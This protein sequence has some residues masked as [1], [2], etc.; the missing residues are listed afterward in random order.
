[1]SQT[2]SAA[3]DYVETVQRWRE[4]QE[5]ELRAPGGW[6]S[7]IGLFWL[8]QG[9]NPL[10]S[11]EGA[12]VRLPERLPAHMGVITLRGEHVTLRMDE[13]HTVVVDGQP[14]EREAVLSD[15]SAAGPTQVQ[16][17]QVT[18]FVIRRGE[19][20]AIRMKDADSEARRS[21]GG[22]AWFPV[23][24]ALRLR[25][26]FTPHDAPRVTEVDTIIG[27]RSRHNSLGVVRFTLGGAEQ[28]LEAFEAGGDSLWFIFRDATSGQQTYAASR[29]L[30]AERLDAHTVDLDFNRA[31]H[32]PCAFT[33]HATCPL[34]PPGNHLRVPVLAGERL[35][36]GSTPA[37]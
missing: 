13:G 34:P 4:A 36:V 28:Q 17:E 9:D 3:P 20:L 14:G 24:E 11:A 6:L 33:A 10:G 31:V 15:D 25:A 37:H 23:D 35:P 26:Q 12:Q 21:F 18:F 7:V 27:T 29:F 16:I 5:A 22:R 1:M 19:R 30:Q 8:Q 32:P 2:S